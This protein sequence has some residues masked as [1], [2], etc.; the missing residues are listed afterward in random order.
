MPSVEVRIAIVVICVI[1]LYLKR[2][3]FFEK[4]KEKR[5]KQGQKQAQAERRQK[6]QERKRRA[7][8][9]QERKAQET[10]EVLRRSVVGLDQKSIEAGD[11]EIFYLEGGPKGAEAPTV[12]LLHSFAGDKE[13]WAELAQRLAAKRLRVIAPDL[14]GWGQN[15]KKPEASYDT[16]Q[17][18]KQLR[19]FAHAL[20]LDKVHLV[21]CGIGATIAGAW[22][23]GASDQ[24]QSLTLI[25][26][27]GIGLP[28]KSELDEWLDQDRNPLVIVAPAAYDN[29]L[30]FLYHQPPEM[31][32]K[33]KQYRAEQICQNRKL[34]VK[35]WQQ[36]YHGE[37]AK[38]LDLV[39]PELKL[40]ILLLLGE[41]SRMV[42]GAT[43]QAM[44]N[45]KPRARIAVIPDAG[46]FVMAEKPA[47]VAEHLL[48]LLGV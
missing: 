45:M 33:L 37:R 46:H 7:V 8:E 32:E 27:F 48:P 1:L 2:S 16:A 42:H 28:Y 6:L 38:L 18:T 34:Y 43:A 19:L 30:S 35:M 13:T 29:L 12:V 31:P 39:L 17:L 5:E 4:M 24:V 25:E 11:S 10:A 41:K 26:P 40:P 9:K 23:Y 47:A 22:A 14:P 20:G 36:I 15:P 21:G 3:G 44:E